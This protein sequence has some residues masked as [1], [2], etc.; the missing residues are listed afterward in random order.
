LTAERFVAN[1]FGMAGERM[2]RTGD[3]VQWRAD[4]NLEF[5]GRADRQIKIR[6]FRV[7][8]GEI[9]VALRSQAGVQDAVVIAQG[10]S[11]QKQL[12]A[13]VVPEA[14]DSLDGRRLW[15]ELGI[16]LPHYMVPA[17]VM[18]L[19]ALPLTPN[20]KVDQKA[21]P[22]PEFIPTAAYR[23]PR[24]PEEEILCQLFVEVLGVKRVGLD[25]NFFES[26]GTSLTMIRALARIRTAFQVQIP[27]KAFFEAPTVSSMAGEIERIRQT[28]LLSN[29]ID[30]TPNLAA[31]AVLDPMITISVQTHDS[32]PARPNVLLT[33]ASG[34]L[35]TFLL[36]ELLKSTESRVTCLTRALNPEEARARITQKLKAFGVW[37]QISDDRIIP[38]PGDLSKPLLGLS[39]RQFEEMS[40]V[41]DVIYH[42]GAMVNLLYPYHALKPTNVNGTEEIL[43]MAS[44]GRPKTVHFVSTLSVFDPGDPNSQSAALYEDQPLGNWQNLP[45]GYAQSKWAGEKL[46][47]EAGNRGIPVVIYRPSSITG[48]TIT[49]ACNPRDFLSQFIRACI[50]LSCVPDVEAKINMVPVDYISK[51]L[52]ALSTL[53]EVVGRRFHLINLQ[54]TQLHELLECLICSGLPV[55]KVSYKTWRSRC[56]SSNIILP[57]FFAERRND[58]TWTDERFDGRS[59]LNLLARVGI[60]CPLITP[61]LLRLYVSYMLDHPEHGELG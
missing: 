30:A 25:D 47:S 40:K 36:A 34:F 61:H 17:V 1:P 8:P 53:D 46:I 26:G 45:S 51:A 44:R 6:G 11:E 43:R 52:I 7:E 49:G 9:E 59:T 42:N 56:E 39:Q 14:A 3:L 31:D 24:T 27:L 22:A 29:T 35:G 33:G 37:D 18:V 10:E 23:A 19:P 28:G 2:Y 50:Q 48:H 15:Q 60:E 21:L 57:A 38:I 4:G 13:Y 54:P 12:V 32:V 20:G 5:V 41:I 55:Q 16:I 58:A